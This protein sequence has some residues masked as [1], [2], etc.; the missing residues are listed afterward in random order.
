MSEVP[1]NSYRLMRPKGEDYYSA[2]TFTQGDLENATSGFVRKLTPEEL[3]QVASEAQAIIAADGYWD[4]LEQAVK[5]LGFEDKEEDAQHG[6]EK[7]D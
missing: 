7:P 1:E 2:A 3:E 4:A 6:D 5:N